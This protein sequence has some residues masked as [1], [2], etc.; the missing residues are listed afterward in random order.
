MTSFIIDPL[1]PP[2]TLRDNIRVKFLQQFHPIKFFTANFLVLPFLHVNVTK[3]SGISKL[4]FKVFGAEMTTL[5]EDG[6]EKIWGC[7]TVGVGKRHQSQRAAIL[8]NLPER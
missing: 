5:W 6:G 8:M 4:A 1:L 7:C 3:E 2:L